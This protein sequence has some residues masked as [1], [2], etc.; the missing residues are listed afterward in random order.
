MSLL[1]NVIFPP[2]AATVTFLGNSTTI[3]E[4][5]KCVSG[6]FAAMSKVFLHQ[7]TQEGT[8]EVEVCA[9]SRQLE[10]L[11]LMVLLFYLAI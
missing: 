4:L 11:V 3:Q 1:L 2:E 8:D 6:W 9:A 7:Y 10:D 5:F